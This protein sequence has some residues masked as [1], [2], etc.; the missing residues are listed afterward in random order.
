MKD[1]EE[2]LKEKEMQSNLY[3]SDDLDDS[4]SIRSGSTLHHVGKHSSSTESDVEKE[5][6]D[7]SIQFD[8]QDFP[9]IGVGTSMNID[10]GKKGKEELNSS[11]LTMPEDAG[12]KS[13]RQSQ[14][15]SAN[16]SISNGVSPNM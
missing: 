9:E 2:E 1:D 4:D 11:K 8:P 6:E 12:H 7:K 3:M 13:R 16:N 5:L 10:K 15:V 14:P